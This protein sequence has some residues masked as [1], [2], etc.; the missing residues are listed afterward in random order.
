MMKDECVA[1]SIDGECHSTYN[2]NRIDVN[3]TFKADH[4]VGCLAPPPNFLYTVYPI[5]TKG[6]NPNSK[7][8]YCNDL[9]I[10]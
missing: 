1:Q 2:T 4:T 5:D 7:K 10:S 8:K 9:L 6:Y 3:V